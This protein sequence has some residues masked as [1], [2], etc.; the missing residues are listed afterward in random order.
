MT[1]VDRS[2]SSASLTATGTPILEFPPI[3]TRR[4][5]LR[6][7][8]AGIFTTMSVT[9]IHTDADAAAEPESSGLGPSDGLGPLFC[10]LGPIEFADQC[11]DASR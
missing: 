10:L 3:S 1:R 8:M 5:S 9:A 7:H 2:C 4:S 11:I 6:N